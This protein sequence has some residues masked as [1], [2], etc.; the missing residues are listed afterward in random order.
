[1]P[2][3]WLFHRRGWD[4]GLPAVARRLHCSICRGQGG[5]VVQPRMTVGRD[6]LTCEQLPYPETG[7]ATGSRPTGVMRSDWPSCCL[8]AN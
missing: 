3:W 2:L 4:D 1:M 7:K 8:L 6:P 5:P